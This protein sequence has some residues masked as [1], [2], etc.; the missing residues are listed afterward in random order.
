MSSTGNARSRLSGVLILLFTLAGYIAFLGLF[1]IFIGWS[2]SLFIP[3]TIDSPP[4]WFE[5]AS[6]AQAVAVDLSL[7]LLFGLQHSV[8]ARAPFKKWLTRW[9]PK[10]A[11][12][13]AYVWAS[14]GMLALIVLA[15]QP[16]P[17]SLWQAEGIIDGIV[18]TINLAGW[19]LLVLSTFMVDHWDF[20]G[21]RQAW[22]YLVS[23]VPTSSHFV[24]RYAYRFVRHPMMTAIM[25]GLWVVPT[26]SWGHLILS[27]GFTVYILIGTRFEEA[28]LEQ[29]LGEPYRVYKQRI[30]MLIPRP[31]ASVPDDRRER[32][33]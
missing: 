10:A 31:G 7:I 23:K 27:A 4:L 24:T 17:Q 9:L 5:V 26:M 8:M 14:N 11:E 19:T 22:A 32:R 33:Q 13:A 18:L 12:R 15:W 29:E 1:V 2:V 16:L 3:H 21:L 6:P 30:P 28:D 20:V 25:V